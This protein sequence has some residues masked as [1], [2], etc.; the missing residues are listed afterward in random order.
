MNYLD[1]SI[2]F[3]Y[4]IGFI[5]LGFV[6]KKNESSKDYFLGGNSLGCCTYCHVVHHDSHHTTFVPFGYSEY[7]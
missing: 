4:L 6:F 1:Y 3:I 7:I 2:I 5:L